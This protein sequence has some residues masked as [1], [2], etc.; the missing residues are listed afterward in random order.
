MPQKS[1]FNSHVIILVLIMVLAAALRLYMLS[2]NM[3]LHRGA[4]HY[5]RKLLKERLH[6]SDKPFQHPFGAEVANVAYSIVCKKDGLSNPFGDSTGPT[7]WVAPGMAVIYACSFYIFGCYTF[8]AIVF[9]FLIALCLSLGMIFLV[10]RLAFILYGNTSVGYLA[11]LLFALSP[12]DLRVF[13]HIDLQD[14]NFMIFLFLLVIYV[15]LLFFISRTAKHLIFFALAT[16]GAVLC[17]PIFIIPSVVSLLFILFR[18]KHR[19]KAGFQLAIFLGIVLLLI[20]P[21]ILYQYKQIHAWTFVKSNGMFELY[22]GNVP[23]FKGVLVNELFEKYHPMM[24][25]NEFLQYKAMGEI[26]YIRS[27]GNRFLENFDSAAFVKR[28]AHRIYNFFFLLPPFTFD[29]GLMRQLV[30][31]RGLILVLYVLMYYKKMDSREWL[32]YLFILCYTFPYCLCSIMY[33]YS[34]P[35]VSVE[36]ICAA[37]IINQTILTLRGMWYRKKFSTTV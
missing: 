28:T 14:F 1:N 35:I 36:M 22:L 37:F 34:I 19:I 24:N 31:S 25:Q 30:F 5:D 29:K 33:R 15:L 18:T 23:D 17:N 26:D 21:Y 11:A 7:G 32:L 12:H 16:V 27:R 8:K 20:F 6:A 9:L 10:Y 3:D 4:F 2:L 13:K